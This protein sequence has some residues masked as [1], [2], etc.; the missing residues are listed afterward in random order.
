MEVVKESRSTVWEDG[1]LEGG[2]AGTVL[3]GGG[4]EGIPSSPWQ[5]S[6]S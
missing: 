3:E 4:L 1:G 5:L 2:G 6:V